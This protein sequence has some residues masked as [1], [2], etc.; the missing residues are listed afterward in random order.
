MTITYSET[1]LQAKFLD[2]QV[3]VTRRVEILE[4]DGQTLWEDSQGEN[5]RLI[6]GSISIDYTRDERRSLDCQLAN[7]D[8]KL[9]HRPEGFW[10]DKVLRAY[11]GIKF[12]DTEG[13]KYHEYPLGTF[14]IDRVVQP[15]FPRTIQ[16]TARD[17]TKKC[18]LS[19]F[20]VTTQFVKG[21]NVAD[22][23]NSL[24]ANSGIFNRLIPPTSK[25]LGSDTTFDRG[26][27]RWEA[28]K[29]IAEAF[30]FELFFNA[31]NFLVMREFI[32]PTLGP[33]SHIF[34]TGPQ[35]G[36][37]VDW[38]KS[39]NDTR[40]FNWVSV[41][42]TTDAGLPIEYSAKNEDPNSPTSIDKIGPRVYPFESSVVTTLAQAQELADSLLSV[43]S[44]EE[45]EI[46]MSSLVSPW[47]E[48]GE[49]ARFLD[50]DAVT[51]DPDRF[52]MTSLTMPLGL[53]A[54]TALGRRLTI[55]G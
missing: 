9:V 20:T 6:S 47:L 3:H 14:L 27:S 49:I 12:R 30:N 1:D 8:K 2:P 45:Y 11:R 35:V 43:N 54:M 29:Q 55:V 22:I 7:F 46:D 31:Q 34:Q 17:F 24:A 41:Q 10:Y 32:D 53:E 25:V 13:I 16:I 51:N 19:K 5:S 52:L 44:L 18:M 4:S 36:N 33:I 28:M 15:R 26:T 38:T 39:T 40:I 48:A 42:G 37:L 21:T 23:I 50:P